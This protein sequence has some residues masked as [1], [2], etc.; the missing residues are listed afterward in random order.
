MAAAAVAAAVLLAKSEAAPVVMSVHGKSGGARGTLPAFLRAPRLAGA[1]YV[2]PPETGLGLR[3]VKHATR[4]VIDLRVKVSGWHGPLREIGTPESASFAEGGD[5]LQAALVLA[6]RLRSNAFAGCEVNVGRVIAGDRAGVVPLT[7]E[8]EMRVLFD[9][10]R[11][12]A[13]LIAGAESD[14]AHCK[15]YAAVRDVSRWSWRR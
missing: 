2:H 13:D 15:L 14:I 4:G 6:E 1:L 10:P 11:T 8:M 12:A 9:T 3:Q 5:A 7:S